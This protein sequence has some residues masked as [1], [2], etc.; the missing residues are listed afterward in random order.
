M[1][2]VLPVRQ[3]FGRIKGKHKMDILYALCGSACPIQSL[4]NLFHRGGEKSFYFQ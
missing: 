2:A 1:F 4:L 3:F